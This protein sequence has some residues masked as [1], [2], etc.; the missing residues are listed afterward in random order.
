MDKDSKTIIAFAILIVFLAVFILPKPIPTRNLSGV[1]E[2]GVISPTDETYPEYLYLAELAENELNTL[3]NQSDLGISF[4]F[5]VSSGEDSPA[6]TLEIVMESWRQDVDLFVAGGY[7]S[8]LTVI[9]SF[10]DDNHI[11]VLSPSSTNIDMNRD[12]YI[13]RISPNDSVYAPSLASL[14]MDYG[15]ESVIVI[16]RE[17]V[18]NRDGASFSDSY[19][20]H[21]GEVIDIISYPWETEFNSSF[22]QIMTLIEPHGASDSSIG[23]LLLDYVQADTIQQLSESYPLLS[24]VTWINMDAYRYPSLDIVSNASL[25]NFLSISP[26]LV[27]SNKTEMIEEMFV[28]RFGNELDF[29]DGCVYDSCMLLGLS[30]IALDSSNSSIL[31]DELPSV[32]SGYVGLTGTV[33]FDNYGDRDVFR[34]GLF[35]YNYDEIPEWKYVGFFDY[36]LPHQ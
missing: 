10:V 6:R 14:L 17:S 16:G 24:N 28:S 26:V 23:I 19:M 29:D 34:M 18:V 13:Y 31:R 1:I 20:E 15:I 32:A 12:D 27:P 2:I 35:E 3:C 36:P 7:H 30:V 21:G 33:G 22:N 11:L 9:R 8:Q 4:I 25:V 5:N